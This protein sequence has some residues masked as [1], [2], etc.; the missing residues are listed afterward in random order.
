MRSPSPRDIGVPPARPRPSGRVL[1]EALAFAFVAW[2]FLTVTVAGSTVVYVEAE[3]DAEGARKYT[4]RVQGV[5]EA[6]HVV[7]RLDGV[8]E[9]LLES[10]DVLVGSPAEE[11]D[12]IVEPRAEWN[13]DWANPPP[14]GTLVAAVQLDIVRAGEAPRIG[15]D[16]TTLTFRLTKEDL[17]HAAVEAEEVRVARWTGTNWLD[18]P[19]ALVWEETAGY[20]F[21][22]SGP[23]DGLFAI[24]AAGQGY[25][26]DASMMELGWIV[27]GVIGL[28]A[29]VGVVL[30]KLRDRSVRELR[31]EH[32]HRKRPWE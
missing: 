15:A 23:G 2:L 8:G 9:H 32:D 12:L 11:L 6:T 27:G 5:T 3:S 25:P 17:V 14:Y 22:A 13:G 7:L 19:T 29:L 30:F 28:N 24:H 20:R 18:L 21:S 26:G 10:V 1:P 16:F 31:R 4:G